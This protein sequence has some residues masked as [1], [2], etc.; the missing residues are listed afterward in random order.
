MVR[1]QSREIGPRP[2]EYVVPPPHAPDPPPYRP[3]GSNGLNGGDSGRGAQFATIIHAPTPPRT[4]RDSPRG[5]RTQVV[6]YEPSPRTSA[7]SL[8]SQRSQGSRTGRPHRRTYSNSDGSAGVPL[9]RHGSRRENGRSSNL[10]VVSPPSPESST[11]VQVAPIRLERERSRSR[12]RPSPSE[13]ALE[14]QRLLADES[15]KRR[16]TASNYIPRHVSRTDTNRETRQRSRER[17]RDGPRI[18]LTLGP[19]DKE[20]ADATKA[21]SLSQK[22]GAIEEPRPRGRS[23]TYEVSPRASGRV[24]RERVLIQGDDGRRREYYQKSP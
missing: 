15:H 13:A 10:F 24:D 18:V 5:S 23:L 16:G 22:E 9:S 6:V 20:L 7:R 12:H 2:S 14:A 4:P 17:S 3:N 11:A 1:V 19:S 21:L 8:G